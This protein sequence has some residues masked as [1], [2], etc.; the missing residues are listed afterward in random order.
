MIHPPSMWKFVA[1]VGCSCLDD[2][3]EPGERLSHVATKF[4]QIFFRNSRKFEFVLVHIG[5]EWL[6]KELKT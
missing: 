6:R 1:K 3:K 2:A 5:T 4:Q